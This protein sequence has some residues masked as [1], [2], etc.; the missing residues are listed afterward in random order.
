MGVRFPARGGPSVSPFRRQN[1]HRGG[2]SDPDQGP[3]DRGQGLRGRTALSTSEAVLVVAA[4]GRHS[5][6]RS[7]GLIPRDMG[8][9]IDVLWM[10]L[11][12]HPDDPNLPLGRIDAG[13]ML[14]MLERGDYF[15]CAYV[16]PKGRYDAIRAEGL[17]AF[18]DRIAAI[19]P[20]M[21]D[22]VQ[23]LGDWDDIKLLTVAVDRLETWW[24]PGLLFVGDSAHAMSPIGGVGVNIAV[25]DAVAAANILA[26]PLRRGRP[27]DAVLARIQRRREGPVR[28]MQSIQL[29]I[30]NRV[31]APVL[32]GGAALKI[33]WPVKLLDRF[34]LLRR[35]PARIV[36]MATW[37]MY[38]WPSGVSFA[39]P[40]VRP[41][42]CCLG[43]RIGVGP[44]V[45]NLV[46]S[47]RVADTLTA[48]VGARDWSGS[49]KP[50]RAAPRPPRCPC[51]LR[52]DLTVGVIRVH[53]DDCVIHAEWISTVMVLPNIGGLRG[54]RRRRPDG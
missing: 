46:R 26:G 19:A 45:P 29:T 30:Q 32:I 15:Q 28:S 6:K 25:Q 18:R 20:T 17:P 22:R 36:G 16:V 7:G 47:I 34:A 10:R 5:T 13:Q 14:V 27:S 38:G 12:R 54:R 50:D 33:P 41:S 53:V 48:R 2:R 11:P 37:N 31:L 40:P 35:L 49:C 24:K 23:A 1:E 52:R 39:L 44:T 21:R 51:A 4:D 9:L 43:H 3:G 42:P 8:Y